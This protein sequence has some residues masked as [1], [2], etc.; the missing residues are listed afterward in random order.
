MV[1]R[2]K[3]FFI[4]GICFL[5]NFAINNFYRPYIYANKINDFGLADIG[6]N[7]VFVPTLY[8]V[9]SIVRKKFIISKYLDIIYLLGV[10]CIAEILSAFVPNIGTFDFRD[11]IGLFIDAILV[12]IF[13]KIEESNVFVK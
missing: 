4:L 12:Y 13:I 10:L 2:S 11:I 9:L 6:N 3:L 7:V 1:K 8:L 5:Y